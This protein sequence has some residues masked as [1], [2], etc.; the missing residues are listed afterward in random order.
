[1][2]VS[3]RRRDRFL[4]EHPFC[5]FCGGEVATQTEDHWPPRSAFISRKWPDG[6]VFPACT[7]CNSA[8]RLDEPLMAMLCR[9]H[10]AAREMDDPEGWKRL[11]GG[12]RQSHPGVLESMR[13]SANQKRRAIKNG[14]AELLPGHTTQDL[15]LVSLN[16]P[17]FLA[18]ARRFAFKLFASLYYK[19]SRKCLPKSGGVQFIMRTNAQ[20]TDDFESQDVAGQL[21]AAPRLVRSAIPLNGQFNYRYGITQDE[22]TPSGLFL[23]RFNRSFTMLGFVYGDSSHYSD[24][25]DRPLLKPNEWR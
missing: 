10:P 9:I 16:H 22:E 3:K 1:M 8:S 24:I 12:I 21:A 17:A 25:G 2:G 19:H 13:M 20:P 18:A 6:Y 14:L 15:P 23:V 7:E 11:L 5:C 4:A